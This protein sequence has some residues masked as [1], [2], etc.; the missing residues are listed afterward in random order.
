MQTRSGCSWC[1]HRSNDAKQIP[2]TPRRSLIQTSVKPA[3]Y[4]GHRA[5]T[6]RTDTK[7]IPSIPEIQRGDGAGILRSCDFFR[8]SRQIH[9]AS[10]LTGESYS[11]TFVSLCELDS[12]NRP[13]LGLA[14]MSV[15]NVIPHDD[16]IL[17]VVGAIQWNSD[18]KVRASVFWQ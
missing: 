13:F 7:T 17:Q 12:K 6:S 10:H 14:T 4:A 5:L 8:P 1:S 16:G 9:A 3:S 15:A 2:A 18:I 11:R